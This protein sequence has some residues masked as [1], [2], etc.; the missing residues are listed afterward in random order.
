[1]A[2]MYFCTTGQSNCK[3]STHS[4]EEWAPHD[5]DRENDMVA[6]LLSAGSVLRKQFAAICYAEGICHYLDEEFIL[7]KQGNGLYAITNLGAILFAKRLNDFP[8]LSRKAVRVVQYQGNN[9][10]NMLKEYTGSKGYAVGFEG[11]LGF[12]DALLPAAEVINGALREKK[13]AYPILAIREAV[14]NA[15]IHQDFSIPGTGPVIEI[16]DGRIEI[17]NPGTPM[18]DIKRIV[19]NPPRSR[20]E[21]LLHLTDITR[22]ISA[23]T[24][25]T[26]DY[27][28]RRIREFLC[29]CQ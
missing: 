28:H 9:R 20:N 13:T 19:D 25:D 17:T 8:R 14:G 15:L 22:Q 2:A 11:L 5:K 10:L 16:F 29:V 23:F 6:C 24:A 12:I 7:V 18:V 3:S 27:N 1:M 26:A 21:K 4:A